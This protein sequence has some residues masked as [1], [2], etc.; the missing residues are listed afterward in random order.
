VLP[1]TVMFCWRQICSAADADVLPE[2]ALKLT[3]SGDADVL[4]QTVM[5][6]RDG[7]V[8]PETVLFCRRC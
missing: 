3:F 4:P 1:E 6:A 2:T 5:F 8:L 7:D